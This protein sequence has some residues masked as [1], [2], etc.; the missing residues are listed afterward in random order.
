MKNILTIYKFNFPFLYNNFEE[1]K[2]KAI[3]SDLKQ[4][5]LYDGSFEKISIKNSKSSEVLDIKFKWWNIKI[6]Y[7]FDNEYYF[8]PR[9]Q[10][11]LF[12]NKNINELLVE[13]ILKVFETMWFK[14]YIFETIWLEKIYI[15]YNVLTIFKLEQNFKKYNHKSFE[16]FLKTTS[17][18]YIDN[19]IRENKVIRNSFFYLIYLCYI[20]FINS[21]NSEKNILKINKLLW[22]HIYDVYSWNLQLWKTR[23]DYLNELNIVYFEKYKK[24]LDKVFELFKWIK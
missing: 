5:L 8:V 14:E 17:K 7:Y 3:V 11:D 18:N 4:L 21:H 6:V 13:N 12:F 22:D 2:Y 24:T 1:V 20:F 15:K 10:L 23:L 19:S 16:L 9:F